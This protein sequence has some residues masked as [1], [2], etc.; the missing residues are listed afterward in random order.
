[1]VSSNKLSKRQTYSSIRFPC[2]GLIV[3]SISFVA[4][5]I[6]AAVSSPGLTHPESL[7]ELTGPAHLG[8]TENELF[9]HVQVD[10]PMPFLRRD[11]AQSFNQLRN[12][13]IKGAG[14]D[15]LVKLGDMLRT[16]GAKS[17]KPGVSF[18]SRHKK[19]EAFDYN[20]EDSSVLLVR[21]YGEKGL[22]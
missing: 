13:V 11:A 2:I 21:E 4:A 6:P 17:S 3:L 16:G 20:Q 22:Q 12:A 7:S 8:E 15:F 19:G 10:A 1:M 9:L 5:I 14:F 18:Y